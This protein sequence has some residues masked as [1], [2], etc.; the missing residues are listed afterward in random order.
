MSTHNIHFHDK[1]RKFPYL[2]SLAI[3]RISYRLKNVFEL[4]VVNEP[5]VFVLLRF[6]SVL[7]ISD[8]KLFESQKR[9][10]ISRGKRAIAVCATE[11][12]QCF[13]NI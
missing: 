5:S 12:R 2:F 1:I 9:V 11:I 8:Q 3:G 13:D 7:T 10:R 6:A 4:A